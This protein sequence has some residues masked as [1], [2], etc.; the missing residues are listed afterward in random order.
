LDHAAAELQGLGWTKGRI[1]L[2]LRRER[3]GAK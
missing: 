1:E 3:S 2:T